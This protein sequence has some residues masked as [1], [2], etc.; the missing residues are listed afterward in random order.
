MAARCN[1]GVTEEDHLFLYWCFIHTF[2]TCDR[3][4]GNGADRESILDSALVKAKELQQVI[5]CSM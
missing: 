1:V 2:F 3:S 4:I 5:I